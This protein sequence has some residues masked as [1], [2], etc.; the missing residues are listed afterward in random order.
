MTW[1]LGNYA[2]CR[3]PL[4]CRIVP[5]RFP[6]VKAFETVSNPKDLESVLELEGWTNDEMVASRIARLEQD[7]WVY[8]R[9]N[10]GIVMPSFLH[11]SSQGMRFTDPVLGAWYASTELTT[12]VLEVSNGL[13][14]EL[15]L[16]GLASK[17]ETYREYHANMDGEFVDIFSTHPEFHDPDDS[18]YP[19]PQKFGALVRAN[20]SEHGVIGIRYQSVRR[21]DHENWV[22]FVPPT[23]LDV[24]AARYF[25]IDVRPTGKVI[26]QQKFPLT[27]ELA[28]PATILGC[29]A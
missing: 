7:L 29:P 27:L 17:R 18:T 12:A 3:P 13:R 2:T 28:G 24:T 20:G 4:T 21:S 19:K 22:C 11:G 6:P 8:G 26:V 1:K 14:K 9:S 15:S 16:S 5:L 23:I 10:A 25:D